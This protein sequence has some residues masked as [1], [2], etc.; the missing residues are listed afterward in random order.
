MAEVDENETPPAKVQIVDE[1]TEV[2]TTP[3]PL[4]SLPSFDFREHVPIHSAERRLHGQIHEDSTGTKWRIMWYPTGNDTNQLYASCYLEAVFEDMEESASTKEVEF[5]LGIVKQD[6]EQENVAKSIELH[7]FSRSSTDWGF[8]QFH[9]LK[10]LHDA[11]NGFVVTAGEEPTVELFVRI[12][13]V[14]VGTCWG[15]VPLDYDSK[16]E[17]GMVGLKNQGATC[18]MN[19]LLQT[20]FHLPRFRQ[21]VYATPTQEDSS[22]E[23]VLLALQRV[24]YRLETYDRPVST[25]ELTKSFGWGHLDSFTQHDV[26]ELFRILCDRLEEKMKSANAENV[27]QQLFEGKV[28][29][30]IRCVN[31][32]F[33]SSRD[34]SFYDIQLDVKGCKDIHES[35]RKY[36]EVEMLKDENQY[37]AEGYGKQDAEKGLSFTSFPPVL[38]VHLK[39]FEYDPMRDGMVKVHDRFEYPQ[40]L[41]LDDY[42]DSQSKPSSDSNVYLLHSILVHY[43]LSLHD[44]LPI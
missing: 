21:A 31:V 34:E 18:Y 2:P 32:D 28:R 37:D 33:T 27:V 3:P 35:F 22:T 10:T 9:E 25:K 38:S 16:K 6:N 1:H 24:F 42:V 39:R 12:Q 36:I 4:D 14:P 7:E 15:G 20:L 17:T 26:Q 30:F 43:T 5:V 23:S 29:S 40:R 41:V 8:K 44:A 19:S 11:A 13:Y